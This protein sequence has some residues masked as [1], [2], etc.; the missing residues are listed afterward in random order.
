[1]GTDWRV[2]WNRPFGRLDY[3]RETEATLATL[4][5]GDGPRLVAL[6]TGDYVKAGMAAPEW[7]LRDA[8]SSWAASGEPRAMV[9]AYPGGAAEA[10]IDRTPSLFGGLER[11]A[12]WVTADVD[13]RRGSY[14]L[15]AA[16]SIAAARLGHSH[17]EDDTLCF[18]LNRMRDPA[19]LLSQLRVQEPRAS[20]DDAVVEVLRRTRLTP[21][22]IDRLG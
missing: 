15:G 22:D 7:D 1:M 11:V 4:L 20:V 2:P 3:R 10:A 6:G 14:V 13:R 16:A 5:G 9:F 19:E 21:A 12:L 18:G 17:I 8:A